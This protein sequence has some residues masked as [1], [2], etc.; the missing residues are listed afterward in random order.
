[1]K[2]IVAV[3]NH[4]HIGKD[5]GM[6]WRCSDDLKHFKA[7]TEGCKCLV[8]RVT[9]DGL[10]PLKNRELLVVSRSGKDGTIPIE[11]A[12]L[13]KPDW[14]IG[15]DAIYRLL[16]SQ[17]TELHISHIND[18]SIGDTTFEVPTDFKGEV[19]H[20]WFEPNYKKAE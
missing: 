13:Q 15:G 4:F 11:E 2:A 18:N 16:V 6:L 3:N 1:M 9:Y 14:V 19:F 17:C 12:L 5:G 7:L 8:G 10:P 20:Y